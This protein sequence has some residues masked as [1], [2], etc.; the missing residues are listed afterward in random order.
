MSL[1]DTKIKSLKPIKKEVYYVADRDG[2]YIAVHPSGKLT[3]V[4]R[5]QVNKKRRKATIG[6]YPEVSIKEARQRTPEEIIILKYGLPKMKK[7]QDGNDLPTPT[8]PFRE[9]AE[10]WLKLKMK[11]LGYTE[12]QINKRQSTYKQIK[13]CFRN[14]MFPA[15]GKRSICKVTKLD[16]LEIQRKIEGRGALSISE[17]YRYWIKE[18]FDYAVAEGVVDVNPATDLHVLAVPYRRNTH[19]PYLK[20]EELPEF[21]DKFNGYYGAYQTKLGLKLLFLTGVRTSEL[22]QANIGQF[23]LDKGLWVIPADTV[24]QLKS[25]VRKE[26]DAVPPYIVPL[27]KQAIEVVKELESIS[28]KNQPYLLCHRTDPKLMVSENTLNKALH[29]IGYKDRLTA[30]GIRATISTALNEWEYPKDWVEAQ[31]SHSDKDA[32][33]ATYNHA[34]YVPQRKEMMQVWSDKLTE[35]GMA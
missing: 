30:H 9:Y 26:G 13:N 35:F 5:I 19:N 16:C 7:D 33:R 4:V 3:W 8:T 2:L 18:I 21:F 24:K 11:K 6:P 23:D 10:R 32:I 15:I 28:Y 12:E 27:S 1:N 22:R 29:V 34:K 31:L 20:V 25:L 17:K 14:D